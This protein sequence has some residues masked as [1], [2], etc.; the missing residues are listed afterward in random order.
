MAW[1][2]DFRRLIEGLTE[3]SGRLASYL[4]V[5]IVAITSFE[6]ISRYVFNEPT[7][8]AW[9][10]NRQ[11]FGVF[12]LFAGSYAMKEGAHIRIEIF[13][14]HFPEWFKRISRLVA[15]VAFVG[16]V[17]VLVWQSAWMGLNSLEMNEKVA[18]AFRM[19]LYPFKLL[20]PVAALLFLLQGLF[21]HLK[22]K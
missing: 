21:S 17:G 13:Y 3:W 19:P 10:L 8:F 12:I 16:F 14:D 1:V 18:G 4:I 6:V 20:I 7:S 5:L 15:L 11:L 2:K 22:K 9:P